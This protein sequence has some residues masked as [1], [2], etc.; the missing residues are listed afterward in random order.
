[1][2]EYDPQG[3]VRNPDHVTLHYCDRG[4]SYMAHTTRIRRSGTRE[5][6]IDLAELCISVS[7][8]CSKTGHHGPRAAAGVYFGEGS[9][10]SWAGEL[11]P[12]SNRLTD[13]TAELF[14]TIRALRI[15]TDQRVRHGGPWNDIRTIV[16][17]TDSEFVFKAMT[18]YVW[19]WQVNGWLNAKGLPIVNIKK[20]QALHNT[21]LDLEASGIRVV[22][23]CVHKNHNTEAIDLA[24]SFL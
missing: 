12:Q 5:L 15:F 19:R 11:N 21:I 1:M 16:L 23:W 10:Y 2:A 13:Q 24:G 18:R 3:R 8:F 17:I 6:E 4:L 20:I 7:G 14:A 22:L 9:P